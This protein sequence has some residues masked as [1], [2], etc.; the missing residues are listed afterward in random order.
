MVGSRAGIAAQTCDVSCMFLNVGGGGAEKIAA[1]VAQ[2]HGFDVYAFVETWAAEDTCN[3][4]GYPGYTA[5]HCVRPVPTGLGRRSGG[6]TVL[7]RN[8][9]PVGGGAGDVAVWRDAAAGMLCVE[10]PKFA[11]TFCVCYFSP[12]SSPMYADGRLNQDP[13]AGMFHRLAMI[14]AQEHRVVLL[15]DFNIRLGRLPGDVAAPEEVHNV[16]DF[17]HGSVDAFTHAYAAV[18]MHR[19]NVDLIVPDVDVASSF[20]RELHNAR[21]VLLNGRTPDDAQGAYT[22]HR[23][24]GG[25]VARSTIDLAI[26]SHSLYK[27]VRKFKVCQFNRSISTDHCALHLHLAAVPAVLSPLLATGAANHRG[28]RVHRPVGCQGHRA[29]LDALWLRADA[30]R[31]LAHDLSHVACDTDVAVSSLLALLGSC[32]GRSA[33]PRGVDQLA[34]G[35][36]GHAG[37]APWFDGECKGASRALKLAWNRH[38]VYPQDVVVRDAAMAARKLYKHML[39]RKKYAYQRQHQLT[40][41]ASY[42]GSGPRAFWKS[43]LGKQD[44]KCP[45][46]DVGEWT[47]HF[48]GIMGVAPEPIVLSSDQQQV[49]SLLQARLS[50]VMGEDDTSRLNAAITEDEVACIMRGLPNGKA[51][52]IM[53]LTCELL[54]VPAALLPVRAPGNGAM[55]D[56]HLALRRADD[57]VVFQPLLA[58]ITLLS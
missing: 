56:P 18:P 17:M 49:K 25:S 33:A 31:K 7:L 29:Y 6:I 4:L 27:H 50:R 47:T 37:G 36:G 1:A 22:F 28:R 10:V 53:G 12:A 54:R 23:S 34:V 39:L 43:L 52:D 21:C 15:G 8:R 32:A 30:F 24:V 51:A 26:T 2:W 57:H 3:D 5:H 40:M 42:F 48:K 46:T 9:S 41:L 35:R 58:C 20:L 19:S 14:R 38:L 13:C 55:P 11:V 44:A 16:P 45:I